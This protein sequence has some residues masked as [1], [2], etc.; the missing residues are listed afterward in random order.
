MSINYEERQALAAA[1]GERL[2]PLIDTVRAAVSAHTMG[3]PVV[4]TSVARFVKPSNDTFNVEASHVVWFRPAISTTGHS[5]VYY[6][7]I[8]RQADTLGMQCHGGQLY[9]PLALNPKSEFVSMFSQIR[10][11]LHVLT[12]GY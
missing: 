4:C 6:V 10:V 5:S 3:S 2:Y 1:M 7:G 8:D 11:R 12:R 9:G